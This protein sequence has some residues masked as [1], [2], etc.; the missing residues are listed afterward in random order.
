MAAE[1]TMF[2]PPSVGKGVVREGV[3]R[4]GLGGWVVSGGGGGAIPL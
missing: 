1:I 2:L 3:G 4:G